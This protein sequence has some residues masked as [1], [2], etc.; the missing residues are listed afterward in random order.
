MDQQNN[1]DI[2]D[3]TD[4]I[5]SD[6]D[7]DN[8]DYQ[9]ASTAAATAYITFT[10]TNTPKREPKT[11]SEAKSSPKWPEWEKAIHTELET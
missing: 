3:L 1:N 10:K 4:L 8:N 2:P 6:L 5:L 9:S 11:L 7:E